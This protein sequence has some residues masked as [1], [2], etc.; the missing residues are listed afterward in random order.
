MT[1]DPW[2]HMLLA[3]EPAYDTYKMVLEYGPKYVPILTYIDNK[4]VWEI[5]I[6]EQWPDGID[7]GTTESGTA[8]DTRCTWCESQLRSWP[9]V[10]RWS[11][12]QWH[13]KSKK[14][15]EKF[16]TLFTLKWAQ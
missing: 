12:Q 16:R 9:D 14:D 15:A 3:I 7:Y 4:G 5:R 2:Q 11:W 1:V 13:F 10:S 8:L 6:Q